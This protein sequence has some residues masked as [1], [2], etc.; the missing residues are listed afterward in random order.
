VRKNTYTNG[1]G[2]TNKARVEL[3]Q[4]MMASNRLATDTPSEN[5]N[6][7]QQKE[8]MRDGIDMKKK[9]LQLL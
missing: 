2:L 3:Q 1:Y 7:R 9:R 5:S 8:L 6:S 4:S